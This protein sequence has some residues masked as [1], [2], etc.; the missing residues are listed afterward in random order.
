MSNFHITYT[1]SSKVIR[2]LC[3]IVNKCAQ[4]GTSHDEAFYGDL[5]QQAYEH[6]QVTSGNP[7]HVTAEDLGLGNVNARILA[8]MNA[9]GMSR[10]W[11]THKGETIVDHDNVPIMFHGVQAENRQYLLWH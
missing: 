1:G 7:H 9:I 2:R 8:I 11:K 10:L 3:E 6:S 5:G 4:L